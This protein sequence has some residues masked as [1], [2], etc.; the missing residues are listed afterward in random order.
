M[1]LWVESNKASVRRRGDTKWFPSFLRGY[2]LCLESAF[3][4][5]PNA[6]TLRPSVFNYLVISVTVLPN[7]Q[8]RV[9]QTAAHKLLNC[10]SNCLPRNPVGLITSGWPLAAG[11]GPRAR[12]HLGKQYWWLSASTYPPAPGLSY[13]HDHLHAGFWTAV[14]FLSFDVGCLFLCAFIFWEL[15]AGMRERCF[16]FLNCRTLKLFHKNCVLLKARP[17]SS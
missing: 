4:L 14:T 17:L 9:P 2:D 7:C 15:R 6:N 3:T 5:H 11:A 13:S 16:C 8:P 1:K 10:L 12:R